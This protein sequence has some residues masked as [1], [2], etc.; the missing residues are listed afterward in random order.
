MKYNEN[1]VKFSGKSYSIN[2]DHFALAHAID[3]SFPLSASSKKYGAFFFSV[4]QHVFVVFTYCATGSSN[5]VQ[6]LFRREFP[7]SRVPYRLTII[8]NVDKYLEQG[9]STDS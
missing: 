1:S 2:I 6:G 4:E 8:R 3:M 5:Q 9:E 7:R